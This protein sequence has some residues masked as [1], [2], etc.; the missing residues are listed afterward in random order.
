MNKEQEEALGFSQAVRSGDLLFCSGQIGQEENGDI[1]RD[2]V[3]QFRLVFEAIGAV[4]AANELT[5]TDIVD[6][7][8][9]HVDYPEHL[10]EF[11][12]EKARFL[13]SSRPTWTAVGVASLGYPEI[14]V[15]VKV[16]A[17]FRG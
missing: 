11:V 15:E 1:P 16:I 3:R 8:S 5:S 9:F 2:P 13:G 4:L 14:L 7:N 12:T 6:M 10:E 17:K